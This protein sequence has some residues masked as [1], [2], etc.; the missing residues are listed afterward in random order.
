MYSS[1]GSPAVSVRTPKN[2][3]PQNVLKQKEHMKV[4]PFIGIYSPQNHWHRL[5]HIQFP[6]PINAEGVDNANIYD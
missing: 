5:E 6:I 3:I 4:T 2:K 1:T